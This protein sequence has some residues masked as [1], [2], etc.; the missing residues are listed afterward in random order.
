M[1]HVL[2]SV[3]LNKCCI[4]MK[5]KNLLNI[6]PKQTNSCIFCVLCQKLLIISR[7]KLTQQF[8]Y[9]R[10]N[11]NYLWPGHAKIVFEIALLIWYKFSFITSFGIMSSLMIFSI[12]W[13]EEERLLMSIF[14]IPVICKISFISPIN[15]CLY[16]ITTL[17]FLLNL[18]YS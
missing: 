13:I 9:F 18:S 16:I 12:L 1:I 4:Y 8:H 7:V 6:V 5:N 10:L 15:Q 3:F 14:C 17:S 11:H 2:D